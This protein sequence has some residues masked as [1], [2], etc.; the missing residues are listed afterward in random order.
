MSKELEELKPCPFCGGEAK[1]IT[2][3]DEANFDGDAIVCTSCDA[4]SRVVF[5]EKE[6]LV[7]AWNRRQ[8][9][10]AEPLPYWEPCNPG[11]DPE[12]NGQRSKHCAQLCHGA[13]AALAKHGEAGE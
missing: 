6:G 2:L 12:F 7:D 1:R 9:A 4:C 11:C 13:R 3:D 10:P 8:Q 5:G